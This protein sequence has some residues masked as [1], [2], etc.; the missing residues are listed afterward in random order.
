MLRKLRL[1]F[2]VLQ[3]LE[4]CKYCSLECS[5]LEPNSR[6]AMLCVVEIG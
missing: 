3:S 4:F 6:P 5:D 2:S 1:E